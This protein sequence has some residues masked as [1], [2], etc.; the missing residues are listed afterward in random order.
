MSDEV[1]FYSLFFGVF[2]D[3]LAGSKSTKNTSRHT[4]NYPIVG[5]VNISI[6]SEFILLTRIPD[7]RNVMCLKTL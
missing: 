3:V 6:K 7:L 2:T 5:V 1:S 4:I